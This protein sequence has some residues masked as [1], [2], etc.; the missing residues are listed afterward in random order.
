MIKAYRL[1]KE[2]FCPTCGF[3]HWRD[4]IKTL[5]D[6]T[7]M[8]PTITM[9]Q[10]ITC[11]FCGSPLS[12]VRRMAVMSVDRCICDGCVKLCQELIDAEDE[13]EKR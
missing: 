7:A 6:V 10:E 1:V 11:T 12:E 8:S 9:T 13:A 2:E 5:R 3:V 4:N